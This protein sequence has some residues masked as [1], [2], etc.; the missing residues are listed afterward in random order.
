MLNIQKVKDSLCNTAR[1]MDCIK[2]THSPSAYMPKLMNLIRIELYAQKWEKSLL[3]KEQGYILGY[4]WFRRFGFQW[5]RSSYCLVPKRWEAGSSLY[6]LKTGRT[7][8]LLEKLREPKR[9]LADILYVR[10]MDKMHSNYKQSFELMIGITLL[11]GH[12][13]FCNTIP[14]ILYE[15]DPTLVL[16][17]GI[18][19]LLRDII[20]HEG[21]CQPLDEGVICT[22]NPVHKQIASIFQEKSSSL[23]DGDRQNAS[24]RAILIA[25][26]SIMISIMLN[27]AVTSDI[28]QI[29]S[30]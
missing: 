6:A 8:Q 13:A 23:T 12:I 19:G 15:V 7:R 20:M 11:L 17:P 3:L 21:C 22:Q 18:A 30:K 24:H 1:M 4:Q 10:I 14:H 28:T 5:L 29:K 27:A 16:K 25:L 2:S 9:G 26:T